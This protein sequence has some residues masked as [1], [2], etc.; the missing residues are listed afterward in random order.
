MSDY[1]VTPDGKVKVSVNIPLNTLKRMDDR[2][3]KE[4]KT[5]L[6]RKHLCERI[7]NLAFNR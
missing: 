6:T 5:R 1:K 3:K 7:S 4:R 2:R